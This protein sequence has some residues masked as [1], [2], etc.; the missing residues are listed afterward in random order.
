MAH[1]GDAFVLLM[2]RLQLLKAQG[3]TSRA[4]VNQ[5]K[6]VETFPLIYFLAVLII[7]LWRFW[8]QSCS[9]SF[10][11]PGLQHHY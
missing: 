8:L 6:K 7:F 9:A 10:S 1:Y 11:H 4:F 2:L 5:K 3:L